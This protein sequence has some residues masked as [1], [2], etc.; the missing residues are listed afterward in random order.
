[1]INLEPIFEKVKYNALDYIGLFQAPTS[2]LASILSTTVEQNGVEILTNTGQLSDAMK[3]LGADDAEIYRTCLMT[4]VA[5]FREVVNRDPRTVQLDLDRYIQNAIEET[6]LNRDA[7]LQITAAIAYAT[8]TSMNYE[9][10]PPKDAGLITENVATLAYGVCQEKLKSFQ[11]SFEKVV[12]RKSATAVLDFESIEPLVNYGIPR[13][14]YFLGYC[15]LKGIQLEENEARGL[16][17]LTEAA[18]AGDSKAS[19]ALGDY[20]FGKGGSSNWTKAYAYYTGYGSIALTKTRKDAMVS[21]LNHKVYNKKV[22]G[23]CVILFF[24]LA[25]TVIWAPA[26][27]VFDA[28]PFWGWFGVVIQLG[29]L[30]VKIMHYRTKPYDCVYSLPVAML[31]V[32][33]VYMAIRMLF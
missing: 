2:S 33:F 32:W 20:Y 17:L 14:K 24:A 30:V 28:Y 27:T 1:M 8:G 13:A 21:I 3:A 19:A 15:L 31:A 5:G 6:G 9:T 23:L 25:A 26:T 12:F 11:E 7:I 18:D 22:L 16:Q 29:L 4:Q 10:R